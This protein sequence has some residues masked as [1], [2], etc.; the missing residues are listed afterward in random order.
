M[1]ES[2]RVRVAREGTA[3]GDCTTIAPTSR[4]QERRGEARSLEGTTMEGGGIPGW[5]TVPKAS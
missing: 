5:R 3:P 2:S 4:G 1:N